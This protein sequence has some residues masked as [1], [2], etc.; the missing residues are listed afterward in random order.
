M[1]PTSY[2]YTATK[3][4]FMIQRGTFPPF[5]PLTRMVRRH[6]SL[7]RQE[8][9]QPVTVGKEVIQRSFSAH[10]WNAGLDANDTV[11]PPSS[12]FVG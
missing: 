6:G 11:R 2:Q 8:Q 3:L 12:T 5:P 10:E 1:L 7:D 9:H 4:S